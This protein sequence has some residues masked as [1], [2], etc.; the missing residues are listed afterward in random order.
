MPTV[1]AEYITIQATY[2][3]HL[4]ERLDMSNVKLAALRSERLLQ[5]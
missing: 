2:N 1:M 3:A 4:K 5:V